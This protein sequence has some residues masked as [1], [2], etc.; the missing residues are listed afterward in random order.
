[1]KAVGKDMSGSVEFTTWVVLAFAAAVAGLC[2]IFSSSPLVLIPAALAG[3][4]LGYL[5]ERAGRRY[6][7]R[8]FAQ[9][10]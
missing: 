2:W 6:F 7:G 4:Y 3:A 10:P 1:V 5:A 9:G 8:R